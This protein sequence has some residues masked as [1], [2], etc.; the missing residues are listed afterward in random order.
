[1]APGNAYNGSL[2]GHAGNTFCFFN[3]PANRSCRRAQIGNQS[4]AQALRFRRPHGN[5]FRRSGNRPLR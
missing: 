1:V 2:H 5:E 3:G 4:L